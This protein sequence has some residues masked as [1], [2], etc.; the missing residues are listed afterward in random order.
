MCTLV[1]GASGAGPMDV[2]FQV[3][4]LGVVLQ[5]PSTLPL[6]ACVCVCICIAPVCICAHV[7]LCVCACN[8]RMGRGLSEEIGLAA[9]R[10]GR[11]MGE[12]GGVGAR[13]PFHWRRLGDPQ[14][15]TEGLGLC[16]SCEPLTRSRKE[17]R[18][19]GLL[20]GIP[21]LLKISVFF[22]CFVSVEKK[23]KITENPH[24]LSIQV[25]H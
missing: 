7:C 11:A 17:G 23:M 12:P 18:V 10:A 9:L 1:H 14:Q 5:A 22:F 6:C 20:P 24:K 16:N 8:P 4:F 19:C 25:S 3:A 15:E 21:D 2:A 13:G